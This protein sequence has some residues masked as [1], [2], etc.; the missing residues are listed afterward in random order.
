[1]S[2]Y[3]STLT[4]L[5]LGHMIADFPLQT[6]YIY[7]L[8][9]RS[10]IGLLLHAAMHTVITTLLIANPLEVWPMLVLIG[11]AHMVID[12]V[13][14]SVSL[15]GISTRP[16]V[17]FLLD[18]A[19]HGVF[20]A[21]VANLWKVEPLLPAWGC[22]AGLLYAL[23]PFTAMFLWVRQGAPCRQQIDAQPAS[24]PAPRQKAHPLLVWSK[25]SGWPLVAVIIIARM[26]IVML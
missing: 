3:F 19:V 17:M 22:V 8:K 14:Q 21:G 7:H 16:G 25:W 13:K 9:L 18:Q 5:L 15:P 1:M 12:W 23:I 6:N 26:G 10:S 2:T 24:N 11:L 20:L 4:T